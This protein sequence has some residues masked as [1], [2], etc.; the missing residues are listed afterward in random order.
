ME[1]KTVE[2]IN[3]YT[4]SSLNPLEYPE[5]L[6]ELYSVPCFENGY[7]EIIRGKEIGSTKI[8]VEEGDVLVCKYMVVNE[9]L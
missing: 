9:L 7:P 8:T 3:Q 4:G 1:V 5:Q 6:Y 2:E